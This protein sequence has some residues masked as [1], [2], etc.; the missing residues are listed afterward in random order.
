MKISAV[1]ITKQANVY[2][3]GQVTSRSFVTQ[4]GAKKSLGVILPGRYH[5][6]TAAPE[7]MELIQGRC[8]V[9]LDGE[10]AW[11]AY[12]GGESFTVVGDSGFDIEVTELLDYLCHYG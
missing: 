7:V 12:Q 6:G 5:F 10:E 3:D 9:R 1:E 8:N 4:D 2:F 11:S